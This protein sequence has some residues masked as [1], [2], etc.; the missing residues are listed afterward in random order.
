MN[1]CNAVQQI[2][3]VAV[4]VMIRVYV[5]SQ[6][7]DEECSLNWCKRR[8]VLSCS[9]FIKKGS[10]APSPRWFVSGLRVNGLY[11]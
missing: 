6:E 5:W 7:C 1:E 2:I 11:V 3:K 9:F 10:C 4:T 8:K